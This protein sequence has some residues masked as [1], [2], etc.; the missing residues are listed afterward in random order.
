M[1]ITH[2]TVGVR[3]VSRCYRMNVRTEK[4]LSLS[5]WERPCFHLCILCH[6]CLAGTTLNRTCSTCKTCQFFLKLDATSQA[7][8]SVFR[9]TWISN[10]ILCKQQWADYISCITPQRALDKSHPQRAVQTDRHR[11]RRAM[12]TWTLTS[13]LS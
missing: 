12:R 9:F 11:G 4:Y 13:L 1:P 5:V 2:L 8:L 7:F 6:L 10:N 3:F